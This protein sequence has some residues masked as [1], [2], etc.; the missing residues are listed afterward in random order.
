MLHAVN[1]RK[2]KLAAFKGAGERV[3]LEDL[4]TS[5]IFGSLTFLRSQE[6]AFVLSKLWSGLGL[7][8]LA[9]DQDLSIDFWPKML[10]SA[11]GFRD[12]YVEPDV[13]I[14]DASG[15]VVV[16]EVKW[17]APLSDLELSSQWMALE[18][19]RRAKAT[20][21]L[22]VQD[23][24]RYSPSIVECRAALRKAGES[25]WDLKT[26]S[27]REF[28]DQ[29]RKLTIDPDADPGVR[30]WARLVHAFLR[31]EMPG[32]MLG[33]DNLELLAVPRLENP[34]YRTRPLAPP[35]VLRWSVQ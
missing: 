22:L 34:I 19:S 30:N 17:G 2:A 25:G 20:H 11:P 5:T 3:P 29:C 12:R 8:P 26:R 14:T 28:G 4:V 33:W 9:I 27:W 7:P 1:Q 21:I 18:P 35:P 16:V 24:R 13:T 32:G 31:R 15:A 6:R 23:P 10:I